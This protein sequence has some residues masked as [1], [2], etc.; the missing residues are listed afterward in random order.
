MKISFQECFKEVRTEESA[1]E[2]V[3]CLKKSGETVFF[4]D[5]KKRL[6][7]GR[8]KWD[9]SVSI[10]MANVS[11]TLKISNRESYQEMDSKYN[12]TMY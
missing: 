5:K 1:A 6:I 12:L 11:K 4:S 8:E 2:C 3:H 9:S 10:Q 7:L